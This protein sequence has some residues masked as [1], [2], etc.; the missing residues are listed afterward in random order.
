MV[1]GG[2]L[3]RSF[4]A[5]LTLGLT[6]GIGSWVG[7]CPVA[8]T[9]DPSLALGAVHPVPGPVMDLLRRGCFDCHSN[10]TR[11]PWYSRI[12]PASWL[13]LRDVERGRGQVNFSQWGRYNP[14]DQADILDKACALASKRKMPLWPYRLLHAEARL[15]DAEIGIVCDWSRAEAARLVNGGM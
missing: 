4:I 11:W 14:F 9:T 13:V 8:A 10:E 2:R 3:R 15:G 1:T 6:I 12:P 5:A 7:P